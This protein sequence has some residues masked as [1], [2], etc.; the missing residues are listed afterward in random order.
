[1]PGLDS[2]GEAFSSNSIR[3]LIFSIGCGRP[4]FLDR[5]GRLEDLARGG[6]G[7]GEQAGGANFGAGLMCGNGREYRAGDID[8]RQSSATAVG[9]CALACSRHP[10]SYSTCQARSRRVLRRVGVRHSA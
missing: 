6:V 4:E 5:V 10:I 1:M 7:I 3:P 2:A 9:F 8:H